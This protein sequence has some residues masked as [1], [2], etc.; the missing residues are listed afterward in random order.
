MSRK[1]LTLLILLYVGYFDSGI[2]WPA[3]QGTQRNTIL[4]TFY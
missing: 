2:F 3:K 4:V 1:M